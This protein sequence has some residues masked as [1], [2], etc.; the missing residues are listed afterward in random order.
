MRATKQQTARQESLAGVDELAKRV[1]KLAALH[2]RLND[3]DGY[4]TRDDAA[5][6]V[7]VDRGP[8][9]GEDGGRG[10]FPDRTRR[11]LLY[12]YTGL[13]YLPDILRQGIDRGRVPVAPTDV[14][15]AANLTTNPNPDDS[16]AATP[17]P[18]D[19]T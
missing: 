9:P 14:R 16:G 13:L 6:R 4:A 3:A 15:Q 8:T 2:E 12:H 11:M 10:P 5:S 17:G 18:I 7:G 19:K 1:E